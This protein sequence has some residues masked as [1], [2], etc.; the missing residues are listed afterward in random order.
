MAGEAYAYLRPTPLL[1]VAIQGAIE[2]AKDV[3]RGGAMYNTSGTFNIG[4]SDVVDSMM[5]I[6]KLV[7]E[8]KRI[9]PGGTEKSG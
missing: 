2:N 4:L 7:F 5:V 3:T 8:E 6:K 9:T 1:S